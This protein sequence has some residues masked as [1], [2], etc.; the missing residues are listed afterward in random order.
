MA[1]SNEVPMGFTKETFSPGMH[2]CYIYNDEEERKR[3]IF[4]FL[5]SGLLNGENVLYIM[6]SNTA[7]EMEEQKL[8]LGLD[9][10]HTGQQGRF[11]SAIARDAYCPTGMFNPDEMLYRLTEFYEQSVE[12]GYTGARASGEMAWATK[13]ASG[14]TRLMEYEARLNN[15]F[16]KCPITAI[17]Q[18][19]AERFDNATL[20]EVLAVHPMIICHGRILKNPYYI[21]SWWLLKKFLGLNEGP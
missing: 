20:R 6:D 2:M 7:G 18:Y 9:K 21:K 14:S 5:E 16:M 11:S 4:R 12:E 10:L 13:K 3:I 19:H 8:A 15:T 1:R 17:C